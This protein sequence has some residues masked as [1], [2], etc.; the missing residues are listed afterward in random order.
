MSFSTTLVPTSRAL[1]GSVRGANWPRTPWVGASNITAEV[2]R[3]RQRPDS[4]YYFQGSGY[5]RE[6]AM[7]GRKKQL[8]GA[9]TRRGTA[10]QCKALANGRCHLHGGLSRGPKTLRGKMK[11]L[12]NLRQYRPLPSQG[13]YE[14]LDL[15]ER[16]VYT[17][18]T[19]GVNK[20]GR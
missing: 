14:V 18:T 15:L 9:R 6:L 7:P 12:Q 1:R 11:A 19:G 5:L 10:C 2:P 17:P 3:V 16:K 20:P 4:L 8:C 13:V